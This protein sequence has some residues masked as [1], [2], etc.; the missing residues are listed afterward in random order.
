MNVDDTVLYA[1]AA[2]FVLACYS[3]SIESGCE[4]RVGAQDGAWG[5]P[6]EVIADA[7]TSRSDR[8]SSGWGWPLVGPEGV[9]DRVFR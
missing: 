2:L 5:V 3:L 1:S 8:T 6:L 4:R 7:I 9:C